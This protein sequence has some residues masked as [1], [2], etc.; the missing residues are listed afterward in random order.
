MGEN[1][2]LAVLG[3]GERRLVA[4]EA[5]LGNIQTGA[6]ACFLKNQ[7]GRLRILKKILAHAGGLCALTREKCKT[8]VHVSFLQNNNQTQRTV[9]N[10]QYF[11]AKCC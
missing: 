2:N 11:F 8:V 7:L 5:Q 1:R 4:L 10:N 9:H 3:A 6:F